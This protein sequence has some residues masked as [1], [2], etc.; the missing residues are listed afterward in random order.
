MDDKTLEKSVEP[1]GTSPSTFWSR[2]GSLLVG[3]VLAA[4]LM[5]NCMLYS[6]YSQEREQHD[7]FAKS[8]QAYEDSNGMLRD[9]IDGQ[10][11][12]I[13]AMLNAGDTVNAAELDAFG[14][15]DQEDADA[16][17]ACRNDPVGLS[18]PRTALGLHGTMAI[19][20]PEPI[21]NEAGRRFF[22]GD[23]CDLGRDEGL[24]VTKAD[25]RAVVIGI[26][27]GDG[28]A[29]DGD[30]PRQAYHVVSGRNSIIEDVILKACLRKR[31]AER[32]GL[33]R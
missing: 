15:I 8:A 25:D 19:D 11:H 13:Q 23:R 20:N 26:D 29:R 24:K 9:Q 4:S 6:S 28:P 22:P 30:C 7:W 16:F 10:R 1:A 31:K 17:S 21:A 33:G 12:D 27:S 5:A 2:N 14:A 32:L 3:C 18:L